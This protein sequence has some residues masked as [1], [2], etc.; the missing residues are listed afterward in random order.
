MKHSIPFSYI[1]MSAAANDGGSH[2]VETYMD[3][4]GEWVAGDN[5][6]IANWTTTT[7]DVVTH[8][9]ELANQALF[10]E[11]DDRIERELTVCSARL[12]ILM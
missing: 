9:V 2:S 10:M 4:T 6:A 11:H 12:A 8:K 5:A 7:G 3:I 1:A